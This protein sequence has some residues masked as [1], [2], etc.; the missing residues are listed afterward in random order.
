MWKSLRR[1][2]LSRQKPQMTETLREFHAR[3]QSAIRRGTHT[4]FMN[5]LTQ[6]EARAY[7]NAFDRW[8]VQVNPQATDEDY[9]WRSLLTSCFFP[10]PRQEQADLKRAVEL[11]PRNV[12]LWVGLGHMALDQQR[13]KEAI[14]YY[15][16]GIQA[17]PGNFFPWYGRAMAYQQLRRFED[18]LRD[19]NEAIEIHPQLAYGYETRGR[20]YDA[21]GE[22]EL[23]VEDLDY[24]VQC[25][26]AR[27]S[28]RQLQKALRSKLQR[29]TAQGG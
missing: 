22:L 28:T 20:I 15:E 24:A 16:A 21:M 25:R 18:A 13:W 14:E 6:H 1:W 11:N 10:D 17:E 12:D 2:W 3:M 29:K 4:E 5:S 19:I 23:A 8:L 26:A 7:L 27:P 9:Y